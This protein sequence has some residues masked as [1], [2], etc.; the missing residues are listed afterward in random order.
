MFSDTTQRDAMSLPPTARTAAETL[1]DRISISDDICQ[2]I[3]VYYDSCVPCVHAK[4]TNLWRLPEHALT[5]LA[6]ADT[7]PHRAEGEAALLEFSGPWDC[8]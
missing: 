1:C 3:N 5:Y 7:I 2:V 6:Q 4:N 8:P